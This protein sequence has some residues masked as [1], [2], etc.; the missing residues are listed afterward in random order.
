MATDRQ[1]DA[2]RRNAR[3]TG[4]RT[5]AGKALSRLNEPDPHPN[6]PK[7]PTTPG[8]TAPTAS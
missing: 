5:P 2:N 1:I 3:P 6:E 7:S 8:L 4:P